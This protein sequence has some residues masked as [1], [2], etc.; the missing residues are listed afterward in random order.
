[1]PNPR[2][3]PPKRKKRSAHSRN[4]RGGNQKRTS[5]DYEEAREELGVPNANS[6]QIAAAE[7]LQTVT[8]PRPPKIKSPLKAEVKK[9]LAEKEL[10]NAKLV[11][12]H[13]RMERKVSSLTAQ[14]QDLSK[15][16]MA[17]KKKSRLA[18]QKLLDDAETMLS[19]SAMERDDLE[20]KMSAAELAV[21]RERQRAQEAVR[22]ERDYMSLSMT[23]GKYRNPF[24]V[25]YSSFILTPHLFYSQT[26]A[27]E[28]D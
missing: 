16:L 17:E 15:A 13:K 24:I 25:C 22:E 28:R 8:N 26:K 1:M 9:Q 6:Q 18:M 2:P 4:V 19:E 21:E 3:K 14:V 23:A 27:Q 11:S 12:A 7:S 20:C 10:Q 5:F